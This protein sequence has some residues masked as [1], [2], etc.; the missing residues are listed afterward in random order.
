MKNEVIAKTELFKLV[1]HEVIVFVNIAPKKRPYLNIC[2]Q[3]RH[4]GRP[5]LG[6][7]NQGI[8]PALD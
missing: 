1:I 4:Q 5:K 3:A 7:H 8:Q 2:Q 6:G